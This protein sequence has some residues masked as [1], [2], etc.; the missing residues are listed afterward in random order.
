[1]SVGS[2]VCQESN[3]SWRYLRWSMKSRFCFSPWEWAK[4]N[5]WTTA[6]EWKCLMY[7][8]LLV[9]RMWKSHGFCTCF[10]CIHVNMYHFHS[11]CRNTAFSECRIF[12]KPALCYS[13]LYKML[14]LN[15]ISKTV[16]KLASMFFKVYFVIHIFTKKCLCFLSDQICNTFWIKDSIYK[17]SIFIF[18]VY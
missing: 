8:F 12:P 14:L 11:S 5:T 1:M 9:E 10:I 16:L 6:M 7:V 3:C 13:L 17:G 18:W 2:A 4:C 15:N